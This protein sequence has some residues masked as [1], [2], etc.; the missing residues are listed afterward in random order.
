M[1]F[2][3]MIRD[4]SKYLP[5]WLSWHFDVIGFDHAYILDH[6]SKDNISQVLRPYI[7]E[8]R[9]TLI[10]TPL[11]MPE[12]LNWYAGRQA[13]VQPT[14]FVGAM[15]RYR[16]QTEYANRA[17]FLT[18]AFLIRPCRWFAIFDIDEFIWVQ[19]GASLK[20]ELE[21]MRKQHANS[22]TMVM[23]AFS[24]KVTEKEEH[25]PLVTQRFKY[26]AS[27]P[28]IISKSIHFVRG[29]LWTACLVLRRLHYST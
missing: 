5:E 9:V 4:H 27:E 17:S 22:V 2:C 15:N 3:T 11:E 7:E 10:P 6:F 24:G 29:H 13:L 23:D 16:Y 21:N 28:K 14:A 1:S 12:N 25:L 19:P 26:K 20:L 8:G 18:P